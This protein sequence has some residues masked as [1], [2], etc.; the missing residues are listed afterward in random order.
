MI[1]QRAPKNLEFFSQI[2]PQIHSS[3]AGHYIY[4]HIYQ[5]KWY[6]IKWVETV[7][8][9]F[10]ELDNHEEAIRELSKKSYNAI[11]YIY[12]RKAV[13]VKMMANNAINNALEIFAKQLT[14]LYR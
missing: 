12:K 7:S 9:D 13:I 4:A 8:H 2:Q 11:Q 3:L 6:G 14:D 1:F 10:K 5:R